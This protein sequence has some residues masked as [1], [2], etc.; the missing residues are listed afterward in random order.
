MAG[1][2]VHR[3]R[4]RHYG[5]S[6]GRGVR[7]GSPQ[8]R[9]TGCP[10]GYKWHTERHR[11]TDENQRR[12]RR[13]SA[14]FCQ[15]PKSVSGINN[16][17]LFSPSLA[18]IVAPWHHLWI[19]EGY[20]SV[21]SF[22]N[23]TLSKAW[24]IHHANINA[25]SFC[26]HHHFAEN[27]FLKILCPNLIFG[28]IIQFDNSICICQS[29]VIFRWIFK[30]SKIYIKRSLKSGS[31]IMNACFPSL[32]NIVAPWHHLWISKGYLS[33]AWSIH[34][35][36]INANSFCLHHHFAG[37][38]SLQILCLYVHMIHDDTRHTLMLL[39]STTRVNII[40]F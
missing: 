16:K 30:W 37:N 28:V 26:L 8:T 3:P 12:D 24:S 20:L 29:S 19:S 18:N 23:K 25:N 7:P 21:R 40:I 31:Y 38:L 36:N 33:K 2:Q 11:R 6:L 32:A 34:H 13:R 35:A 9:R 1:T 17:R 27:L 39:F 4:D 14:V 5:S 10:E 15:L 22:T